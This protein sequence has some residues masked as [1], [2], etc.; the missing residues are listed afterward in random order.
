MKRLLMVGLV[1]LV[2]S[3]PAWGYE[4]D[5]DFTSLGKPECEK[6]LGAYGNITFTAEGKITGP[7]EAFVFVSWMAGYTTAYN[8]YVDNGKANI[9]DSVASNDVLRWI[10]SWCRDNPTQ[11]VRDALEALFSKQ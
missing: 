4:K 9:L 7:H 1:G 6:Y 3:G 8:K 11:D 2:I 5:G 10:A